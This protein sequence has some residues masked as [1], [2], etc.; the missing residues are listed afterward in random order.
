MD[1]PASADID[2]PSVLDAP[3]NFAEQQHSTMW[4]ILARIIHEPY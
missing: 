2:A 3:S 1:S 4:I